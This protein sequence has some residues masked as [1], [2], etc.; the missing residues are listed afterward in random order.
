MLRLQET[1]QGLAEAALGEG[2]KIKLHKL[3]VKELKAVR[4]TLDFPVLSRIGSHITLHH[5]CLDLVEMRT[6]I[7]VVYHLE[8]NPGNRHYVQLSSTIILSLLH[9]S[10]GICCLI[11]LL[12]QNLLQCTNLVSE[13]VI[14]TRALKFGFGRLWTAKMLTLAGTRNT[15]LVPAGA[16]F[17]YCR[18]KALLDPRCRD[19][20]D[21]GHGAKYLCRGLWLAAPI[22][23]LVRG[24]P[25]SARIHAGLS[26]VL[27]SVQYARDT[28]Y[29]IM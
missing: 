17:A 11:F 14:V 6:L 10:G 2:G 24:F 1:K 22:F 16:P 19:R 26:H 21:F 29:W 8:R 3:S 18:L 23:T 20:R 7:R 5:S 15:A 13:P 28:K 4:H 27:E 12:F 9:P 25:W